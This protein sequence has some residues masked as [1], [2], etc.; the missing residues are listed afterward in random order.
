MEYPTE[1]KYQKT[2]EWV[3][4]VDDVAIIGISDFAQNQLSD[5]VFVE[6]NNEPGD[7]VVKGDAFGVVE[8]VKAASDVF[9][10]VSGELIEVNTTLA[11]NPEILNKDP[12]GEGWM[13]KIR[14]S[15]PTELDSLLDWESYQQDT[16]DR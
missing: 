6:F 4:V 8:S 11:D 15:D 2:D 1:L 9:Y 12:Y 10:P 14:M 3:K 7:K 13:L 16:R 5:L